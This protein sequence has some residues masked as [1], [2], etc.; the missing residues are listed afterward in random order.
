[1]LF[2]EPQNRPTTTDFDV[3]AM[4][5]EAEHTPKSSIAGVEF[6]TQHGTAFRKAL[7]TRSSL[8]LGHRGC[9]SFPVF[10]GVG[11]PDCPWGPA[12]RV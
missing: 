12:A 11:P 3:I 10:L 6:Q 1:M 7:R 4:S 9:A 2:D 5:A 8:N